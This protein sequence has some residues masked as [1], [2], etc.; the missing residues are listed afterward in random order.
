MKEKNSKK[1][2]LNAAGIVFLFDSKLCLSNALMLSKSASPMKTPDNANIKTVNND[3]Q[4][5][6]MGTKN[7][8]TCFGFGL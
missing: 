2:P 7:I 6:N 3:A 8:R 5:K 4:T 1:H